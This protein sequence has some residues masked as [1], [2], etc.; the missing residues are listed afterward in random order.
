MSYGLKLFSHPQTDRSLLLF[1]SVQVDVILFFSG[2][3]LSLCFILTT[4]LMGKIYVSPLGDIGL[5]YLSLFG[6]QQ[7]LPSMSSLGRKLQLFFIFLKYYLLFYLFSRA[8]TIL[9]RSSL[10]LNFEIEI[11]TIDEEF[12]IFSGDGMRR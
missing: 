7:L 2:L 6:S 10:F 3:P 1:S 12:R 4:L 11:P 8:N 5:I 9:A